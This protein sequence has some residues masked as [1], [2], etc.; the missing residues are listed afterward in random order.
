[1]QELGCWWRHVAPW[2]NRAESDPWD[3]GLIGKYGERDDLERIASLKT[4]QPRRPTLLI[5]DDPPMGTSKEAIQALKDHQSQ[6]WYPV[7]LLIVDQFVPA[8]LPIDPDAV[9]IAGISM[10][11]RR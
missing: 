11:R 2:R 1:V 8:D 9:A 5:L 6:F 3:V 7:R 10:E 4:W